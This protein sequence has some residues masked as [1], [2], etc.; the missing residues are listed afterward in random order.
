[1]QKHLNLERDLEEELAQLKV[2]LVVE[3]IKDKNQDQV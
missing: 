2:K 3:A 1:M